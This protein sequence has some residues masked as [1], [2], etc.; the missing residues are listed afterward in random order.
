MKET[1][2]II[3][4]KNDFVED[5]IEELRWSRPHKLNYRATLII[6]HHQMFVC[7][8]NKGQRELPGNLKV[9]MEFGQLSK[10]AMNECIVSR[11]FAELKEVYRDFVCVYTD[12][13]KTEEQIGIG[14]WLP[15]TNNEYACRLNDSIC[16]MNGEIYAMFEGIKLGIEC[17]SHIGHQKVVIFPDSKVGMQMIEEGGGL[18][19][20]AFVNE[21]FDW[22]ESQETCDIFLQWIPSHLAIPGNERADMLAER[23]R[24]NEHIVTRGNW[25]GRDVLGV[26]FESIW[27]KW[28]NDFEIRCQSKGKGYRELESTPLRKPFYKSIKGDTR[29]IRTIERVRL[30]HGNWKECLFKRN[31]SVD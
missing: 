2:R 13:S 19:G 15:I 29:M 5:M 18:R 11:V 20:N 27:N 8:D 31:L 9:C 1:V 24:L 4:R 26:L 30:N 12:A 6:Q 10:K 28:V 7:I 21:M 16:I 14:V 17:A 22:L 23:G 3:E 25:D